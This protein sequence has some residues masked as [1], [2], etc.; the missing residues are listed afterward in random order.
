MNICPH[1]SQE[2]NCNEV[3]CA[4]INTD[5]CCLNCNFRETGCNE[6][7]PTFCEYQEEW[8]LTLEGE[9]NK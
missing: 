5:R 8:L 6:E 3:D 2:G 4:Q 1:L 7:M 9:D